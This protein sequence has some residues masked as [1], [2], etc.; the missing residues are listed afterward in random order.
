MNPRMERS[1]SEIRAFPD[2]TRRLI[3]DS[4]IHAI[5]NAIGEQQDSLFIRDSAGRAADRCFQTSA[6]SSALGGSI[7]LMSIKVFEMI[8]DQR[9]TCLRKLFLPPSSR[10]FFLR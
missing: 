8:A 1:R 2:S 5:S 9:A 10:P 4:I 3:A 6:E 7:N